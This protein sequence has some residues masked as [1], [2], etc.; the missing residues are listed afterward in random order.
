LVNLYEVLLG[1]GKLPVLAYANGKRRSLK[2]IAAPVSG[3]VEIAM[4]G[5]IGLLIATVGSIAACLAKRFPAH[6]ETV[7]TAAGVLLL[8]GFALV[9]CALPVMI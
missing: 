4:V 1:T 5:A 7:E 2:V 9:G 3:G 6:T 8:S